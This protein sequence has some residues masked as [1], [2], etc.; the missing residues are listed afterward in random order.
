MGF[1]P[2]VKL[3]LKSKIE[4]QPKNQLQMRISIK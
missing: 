2:D 4:L 1:I 3:Y